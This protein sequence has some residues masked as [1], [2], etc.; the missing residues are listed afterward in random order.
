MNYNDF[1]ELCRAKRILIKDVLPQIGYTRQGLQAALN[2]ETIELRKLKLLCDSV[3]ISPSHFFEPGTFGTVVNAGG[4][5]QSGNN[6][7]MEV[8]S[9]DRE[10]GMLREQVGQLRSQLADKE[11]IIR[12]MRGNK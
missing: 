2:N 4:H 8:E 10:I 7:R 1:S 5:V 11:E 6:N 3:R 12:L 9:R